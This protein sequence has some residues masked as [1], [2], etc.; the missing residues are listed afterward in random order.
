MLAQSWF[1]LIHLI[2]M[3]LLTDQLH[4]QAKLGVTIHMTS[5]MWISNLR[6]VLLYSLLSAFSN[7]WLVIAWQSLLTACD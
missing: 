3:M 1:M 5:V 7:V 2:F 4:V 6:I